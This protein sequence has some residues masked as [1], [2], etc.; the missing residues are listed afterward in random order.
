MN[1]TDALVISV[2][3]QVAQGVCG[4]EG[5]CCSEYMEQDMYNLCEQRN[6]LVRACVEPLKEPTGKAGHSTSKVIQGMAG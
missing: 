3:K 1:D 6:P 4:H 5:A 2:C